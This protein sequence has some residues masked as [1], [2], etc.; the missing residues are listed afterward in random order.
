[1]SYA[2]ESAS[3][4]QERLR[5]E[6]EA[7]AFLSSLGPNFEKARSTSPGPGASPLG[8]RKFT[9]PS[10]QNA[11]GGG[12]KVAVNGAA[13]AG[14]RQAAVSSSPNIQRGGGTVVMVSAEAEEKRQQALRRLKATHC[15]VNQDKV[16]YCC[17][18]LRKAKS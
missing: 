15:S 18:Y 5:R 9:P 2:G 4:V 16:R 13:S 17:A 7:A 6:K 11:S 1:M 10:Q 12:H 3:E 14:H 8:G